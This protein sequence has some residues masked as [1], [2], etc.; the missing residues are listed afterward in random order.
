MPKWFQHETN[1]DAKTHQKSMPKLVAEK[2]V[3]DAGA[4]GKGINKHQK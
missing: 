2:I 1:N 3:L 4:N